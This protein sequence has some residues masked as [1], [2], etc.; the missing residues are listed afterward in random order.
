MSPPQVIRRAARLGG[1]VL[2]HPLAFWSY[3]LRHAA[4]FD[5]RPG[6]HGPGLQGIVTAA[7]EHRTRPFLDL[8]PRTLLPQCELSDIIGPLEAIALPQING[9]NAELP[10]RETQAVAELAATLCS[11]I[12]F[13]IGTY[14]GRTTTLLATC[15]PRAIVHTL[16]LAPERMLDGGCFQELNETLIGLRFRGHAATASRIVQHYGDSRQFDYRPFHGNVDL[17]FVD[18]SHA[19]E[20]VLSDSA[21]ALRMVR[22]GGLIIW[23]DYHPVHGPGVMKALSELSVTTSLLWIRGT[24]LAVH[25]APDSLQPPLPSSVPP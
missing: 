21:A 11:S 25:R 1:H 17:V 16:D 7:I 8:P 14:R 23:D 20:A 15:S 13:E 22:P 2:Q 9:D 6:A 10:Q 12:I 24:R 4:N 19:Y 18:A 5:P 3:M